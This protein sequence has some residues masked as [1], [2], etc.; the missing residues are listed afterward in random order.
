MTVSG[1]SLSR[2]LVVVL[3]ILGVF[4]LA[5]YA[6][7]I[8]LKSGKELEADIIERTDDH[9]IVDF[10]GVDLTYYNEDIAEI[11]KMI[12]DKVC[13]IGNV[14]CGLMDSGTDQ[15]VIESARYALKHG[16]QSGGYIFST[17]NCIYTGMKLD[18]YKLILDVWRKE[19][20]IN[21]S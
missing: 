20:N 12:G 4:S 18:R 8:V 19:G 3:S 16:M 2:V 15:E 7:I 21:A 6:D 11:K 14:N 5:A 17:S 10:H 9:I 13:L 1:N